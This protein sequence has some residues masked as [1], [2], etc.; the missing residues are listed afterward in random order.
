MEL[1]D[2]NSAHNKVSNAC[3]LDLHIILGK[4]KTY[5]VNHIAG[6]I[7]YPIS[8]TAISKNDFH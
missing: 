6:T 5:K 8:L 7:L 3:V 4:K 2:W 1:G